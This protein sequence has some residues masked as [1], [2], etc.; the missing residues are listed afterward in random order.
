M[1]SATLLAQLTE[2]A[3]AA[4]PAR[5][6]EWTTVQV[7]PEAIIFHTPEQLYEFV[8]AEI[9]RSYELGQIPPSQ[10][11]DDMRAGR[12]VWPLRLRHTD[13]FQNL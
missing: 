2:R 4:A 11:V 6:A 13:D 3:R 8:R 9:L 12:Q 5:R 7:S 10:F 1:A